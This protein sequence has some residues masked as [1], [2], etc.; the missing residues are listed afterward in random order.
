MEYIGKRTL[1]ILVM[2]KYPIM[3]FKLFPVVQTKWKIVKCILGDYCLMGIIVGAV[4][5]FFCCLILLFRFICL[6]KISGQDFF[7]LG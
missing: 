5:V 7:T 4:S 1:A 2:H 3:M 6:R